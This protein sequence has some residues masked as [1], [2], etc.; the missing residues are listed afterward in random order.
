MITALRIGPRSLGTN[1]N[2]PAATTK[3]P[4]TTQGSAGPRSETVS[5]A[6]Q[7]VIADRASGGGYYDAKARTKR[8]F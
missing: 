6:C 3:N 2:A 7:N 8:S 4:A 5:M 1:K